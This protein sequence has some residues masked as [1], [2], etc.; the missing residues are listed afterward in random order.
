M[1]RT[2]VLSVIL[3]VVILGIGAGGMKVLTLLRQDPPSVPP[4]HTPLTV[5]AIR[6][7]PTDVVVPL[8]AF[9]TATANRHA[10]IGCEVNG[11][12]V[13]R[14]ESLEPGVRVSTGDVLLRI[15]DRDYL[16]QR[17]RA[18]SLL[19]ADKATLASLDIEE[20]N[21]ERLIETAREEWQL[22]EREYNRVRELLES[23]AS[24]PRELD[25]ARVTVQRARRT[26][27]GLENELALIPQRRARQQATVDLRRAELSTAELN[28]ERCTITAPFD[29]AIDTVRVELG[30]QV[31]PGQQLLTLLE[32]RWIE[33]PLELPVSQRA[34]VQPGAAVQLRL[35]SSPD[36]VWHGTVARI[37]PTADAALRTF[38]LYV[39]VDNETH[40]SPLMPGVFVEAEIDGPTLIDALLVPRGAVRRG[41][42][43][44]CADRTA[45]ERTVRIL[46][47]IRADAAIDGLDPGDVVITSNLDV[48]YDGAPVKPALDGEA[49]R[50]IAQPSTRPD[51]TTASTT[52]E[53]TVTP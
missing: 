45:R 30:E 33:V 3:I 41:R 23:E 48:L 6:L 12:V 17:E 22:A 14:P 4:D 21:T 49:P 15:D 32:P 2:I 38:S 43:F 18:R 20:R 36:A 37:G 24:N 5:N 8:R 39:E 42:A 7:E 35:E 27:Q 51:Q 52:L 50:Q 46:R 34:D 47:N 44:V 25:A 16:A 29:G 28:L 53:P 26:L 9:G 19:A 11:E 10:V 40:D 1:A 13:L 31:A